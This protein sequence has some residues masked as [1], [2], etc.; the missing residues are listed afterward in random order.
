MAWFSL[1]PLYTD[2]PRL[3]PAKGAGRPTTKDI[4]TMH[5]TDD[6]RIP[7]GSD[8]SPRWG[9]IMALRWPGAA[10]CGSRRRYREAFAA[11]VVLVVP[12]ALPGLALIAVVR[13]IAALRNRS[14]EGRRTASENASVGRGG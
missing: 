5:A 14:R 10:G 11:L 1:L 12:G 3:V 7:A 13:S 9:A 6:A 8:V 2:R 4:T